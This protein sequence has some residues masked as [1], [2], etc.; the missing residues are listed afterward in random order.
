MIGT[1][2]RRGRWANHPYVAVGDG[3]RTLLVIP[4]LNDP[5]CRVTDRWWF[6]LL[7]ATYCERYTGRHTVAMVSRPAGLPD[8]AS[9][10]DLAAGY[11]NVLEEVGPADVLG[12]SM[13][14][15]LVEHLAADCPDLLEHAILGLA[16]ARL[17]EH[18][19]TVVE[20]WHAHADRG[21]FRPIYEEAAGAVA[22]GLRGPVVRGAARLYGRL[23]SPPPVDRRDFLVS[24]DA[25]LAHDATD[26]LVDIEVPTLV[27]GGTEDPFFTREHYRET[28]RRIPGAAFVE[29]EEAGHEA[30]L[31]RRGEFDGGIREFLYE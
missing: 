18:G 24:A 4:G 7:V 20:R 16:A 9:T 13:G 1:P 11:S 17:S 8:N 27:I 31:D 15:F 28:V 30:V 23:G 22:V 12:L 5:L 19:R 3:P 10:R 6:S 2:L 26:R 25:C 29:I 21:E 14:G